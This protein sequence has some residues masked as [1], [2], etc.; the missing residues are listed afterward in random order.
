VDLLIR[1]VSEELCASA[2]RVTRIGEPDTTLAVISKGILSDFSYA[3]AG[4]SES[5]PTLNKLIIY[6]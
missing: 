4:N 3:K 1:D 5:N 2:N 6:N